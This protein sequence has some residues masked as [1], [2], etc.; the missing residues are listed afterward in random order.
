MAEENLTLSEAESAQ[1]IDPASALARRQE[2]MRR[3]E[4]TIASGDHVDVRRFEVVD[5]I[6]TL[7]EIKLRVVSDNPD[8]AFDAVIG[9]PM[10]FWMNAGNVRSWSGV[11][12]HAEQVKVE[13]SYLSTYELTLVPTL[14]LTTQRRNFRMFQLMSEIEIV[15]Q[16]LGEWDIKPV[17]RLLEGYK[18]RKYR[19][20]YGETDY[21]FMCRMLEDA[22]VSFYFVQDGEEMQLVLD[23][24]PQASKERPAIKFIERPNASERE[25][26][27]DV[28][29]ARKVRPGKYTMR[30]H[31]YRRHA[32][33]QLVN[34]ATAMHTADDAGVEERLERYHYVPGA[35]LF[36][37]E[38]GGDTPTADD[39]GA[40]RADQEEGAKL[41]QRRLES[42]RANARE[43]KF[44][45]NTIDLAPGTTLS[46][47]D[48]PK[49]DLAAD[50]RLIVLECRFSGDQPGNWAHH[51][52]AVSAN[53]RFTPPLATPKPRV[54]GVESATVVGPAG[55]EIHTDEFGRVRVHF[56]WDRES[57]MDENSSCWIH[58]SQ[59]WSGAGF[60]GTNLPRIGQEVIVDFLGGD[61]DRPIIVGRVYTNLQKTPY[62]LPANKTQSGW[63]SYSSPATGGYNEIKFEDAAGQELVYMQAEKDMQKLVKNNETTL[64]GN[65]RQSQ[66]VGQEAQQIG[67]DFLKQVMQN[68]VESVG[69]MK[70]TQVGQRVSIVCGKSSLIMDA[71]GNIM[72]KGVKILIE[73]EKHIQGLAERIDF[74]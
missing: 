15:E 47:L 30:D 18:K 19:V 28:Q 3:V 9:Q 43:V 63:K 41:A 24:N 69:Q 32:S 55:E 52:R 54:A 35:M 71:E 60:G 6:S 13:E 16:I 53:A 57:R 64:I 14:W 72:L 4:C 45:T 44:R 73:G 10:R 51:V 59:P 49:S 62:G 61:P 65:D 20:Q 21:A 5:T 70:H 25:Y 33:F 17:K 27:T 36:E 2:V 58:V 42:Q 11:C 34:T 46:F 22:G 38:S 50:K 48:H 31:D 12:A 23:D 67:K 8:I 37:A 56:H 68:A 1:S 66:I 40:F 29:V 7:F 74:N 26:V 39:R